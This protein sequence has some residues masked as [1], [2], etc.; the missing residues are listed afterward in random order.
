MRVSV[1]VTVLGC[2]STST[3]RANT[4][5][6]YNK[7]T[8]WHEMMVFQRIMRSSNA[9]AGRQIDQHTTVSK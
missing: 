7:T 5:T 8:D 6:K 1:Q 2:N 3:S 4:T 9:R